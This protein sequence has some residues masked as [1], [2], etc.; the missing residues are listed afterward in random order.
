MSQ[1]VFYQTG[2]DRLEA[3]IL[4]FGQQS[5]KSDD[6][7]DWAKPLVSID[8]EQQAK[9]AL[10]QE[11]GDGTVEPPTAS[12]VMQKAATL[13]TVALRQVLQRMKLLPVEN[14]ESFISFSGIKLM[15]ELIQQLK[16]SDECDAAHAA[17]EEQKKQMKQLVDSVSTGRKDL[18]RENAKHT[19]AVQKEAEDIKKAADEQKKK[20]AA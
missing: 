4:P 1:P 14:T 6:K 12:Q 17:F 3:L 9:D 18:Q 20:N 13:H 5:V 8:F 10:K 19:K 7:R 2:E 11:A 16:T 15:I